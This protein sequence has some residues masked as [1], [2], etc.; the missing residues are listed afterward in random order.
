MKWVVYA[1]AAAYAVVATLFAVTAGWLVVTAA[2]DIWHV[3]L[4]VDA[5]SRSNP[6]VAIFESIGLLAVALVAL[7]IAQ[8]IM[9]EQVIRRA[10]VSAPTRAR[11][12]LSRFLVVIVVALTI[13]TLVATVTFLRTRPS[14]L[15]FAAWVG[16]TAAFV[17]TAWGLFVWFNRAA[18][19]IEPEAMEEAKEEDEKLKVE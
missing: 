17:L 14:D 15:I 2:L 7:E 13:E 18:E 11:R 9:E 3:L 6:A 5:T 12:Y 16:A 19:E 8:T 1:F 10:H 4:G